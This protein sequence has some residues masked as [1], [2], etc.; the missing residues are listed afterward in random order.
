MQKR[1]GEVYLF[2]RQ[3]FRYNVGND[4]LLTGD[5]NFSLT[6]TNMTR[7]IVDYTN[8]INIGAGI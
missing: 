2:V 7:T 8:M 3:Q 1:G 4:S 6:M 5:H